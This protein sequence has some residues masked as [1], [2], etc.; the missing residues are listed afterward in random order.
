MFLIYLI[1]VCQT[2]PFQ[3]HY[4][5]YPNLNFLYANTYMYHLANPSLSHRSHKII[6]FCNH[7][8]IDVRVK[9]RNQGSVASDFVTI[10][11]KIERIFSDV[12]KTAL[13]QRKR[14]F[15]LES[16]VMILFCA[17]LLFFSI[18]T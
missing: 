18:C 16:N 8:T 3:D 7:E 13:G 4:K 17:K 11:I 15:F 2:F 14:R 6:F 9:S 1:Y 12:P 5:V 10:C